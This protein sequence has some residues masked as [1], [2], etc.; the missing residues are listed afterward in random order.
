MISHHHKTVFVHVPK[1][2]GQSVEKL[3]VDDL[4]LDWDTRAPLLLRPNDEPRLGP[5]RLGHLLGSEFVQF[6]Y[7]TQAQFDDY[8]KFAVVR[9]PYARLLSFYNYLPLKR[10]RMRR[11]KL[12]LDEFVMDWLPQQ[13][14]LGQSYQSYPHTYEGMFWFVRPQVDYLV[15]AQG[16][17]LVDDIFRL[18]TIQDDIAKVYEKCGISSRLTHHNASKAATAKRADLSPAHIEVINRLYAAEFDVLGYE[19]A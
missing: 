5:P 9:D 17:L 14:E 6:K 15:D 19:R 10:S 18:E 1:C 13:F 4:G 11:G 7:M 12:T 2:G 3:F 8:Y 16:E